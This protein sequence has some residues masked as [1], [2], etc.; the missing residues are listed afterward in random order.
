[1]QQLIN[2]INC[3]LWIKIHTWRLTLNNVHP[4]VIMQGKLSHRFTHFLYCSGN[5]YIIWMSKPEMGSI[6][7]IK[8][9]WNILVIG[10]NN[11]NYQNYQHVMLLT[12]SDT[13]RTLMRLFLFTNFAPRE[14]VSICTQNIRNSAINFPC[15]RTLQVS[16]PKFQLIFQ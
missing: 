1:M 9:Q 6:F 3:R 10:N 7:H 2:L 8:N 14:L 11:V 5:V 4:K 13:K 15:I 12:S 16:C